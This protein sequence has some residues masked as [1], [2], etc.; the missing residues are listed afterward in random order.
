MTGPI[1]IGLPEGP[2]SEPLTTVQWQVMM[3]I[4]DTIIARCPT[5]TI[6]PL[7]KNTILNNCDASTLDAF[8]AEKP[9]DMPLFQDILKRLLAN[10]P[11]DKLSGIG[12]ICSLLEFTC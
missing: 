1:D 7:Q 10:L 9:S 2:S 12:T 4:M 5:D 3:A 6:S 11:A 8:L